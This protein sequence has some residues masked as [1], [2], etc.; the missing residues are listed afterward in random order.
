MANFPRKSGLAGLMWQYSFF[1]MP[2]AL[3]VASIKALKDDVSN[4]RLHV[5]SYAVKIYN[6]PIALSLFIA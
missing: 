2:G 6:R 1:Y 4:K 5:V 3:P